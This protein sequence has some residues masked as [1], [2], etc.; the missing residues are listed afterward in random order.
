MSD[1]HWEIYLELHLQEEEDVIPV[2]CTVPVSACIFRTA[3]SHSLAASS[4][5]NLLNAHV[6]V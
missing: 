1:E 4:T 2:A 3:S 6:A 5:L